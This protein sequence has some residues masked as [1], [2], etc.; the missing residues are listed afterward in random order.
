[1][2]GGKQTPRQKLIGLMYLI[3]LALM[4]LNVSVEV[5]DS[6]ALVNDG[7][8]Q[9]NRNF[10]SKV[11]QVYGDFRQQEAISKEKVQPYYGEALRIKQLADSLVNNILDGRNEMIAQINEISKEEAAD[12]N[13]LDM[14]KKDNYSFS[15]RFW[16]IDNSVDPSR[17]G[18]QGTRA[19]ALRQHI[20]HFK[21]SVISILD[22]HKLA[23]YVQLGLDVDGPFYLQ[24]K[25]AE[26]SWQQLTFDR[27]IP[28]A[29]ATNMSRLVT[30]VRNAE[31]DAINMLYGAITADDYKFD[32]IA[33]RVVP[34]SQIVLLGE[35]YEA[36][37]FVAAYDSRQRPEIT[38][39]RGS[40]SVADGGVGRLRIPATAEGAQT[41]NGVI[42]LRQ[43][44]TNTPV[45]YPYNGSFIVQRPSVTV[46]AD[47]MNVFYIGL[48]NP[49]SIS[50]PGVPNERIRPTISSGGQLT[51]RGSGRYYV[52]IQ[53][54]T[55]EARITVNADIDGTSRNMG[56]STF[57]VRTVPDPVAYIANRR[58]GRISREELAV[59]RAIIPRLENFEFDMNFEIASFVMA[60]TVAGDFR[61][62]RAESNVFTQEMLNVINTATRGQRFIFENIVT[63]PG[64]DG[65]TRNLA[66]IT[67]TIN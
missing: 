52:R 24:D 39:N 63:K 48:D 27:V 42:T 25:T 7:I 14:K 3:F 20:E 46:S 58:E 22:N 13:L 47:A 34:T 16:M 53:P 66:P 65:R 67:F 41:Y 4:A 37:V 2:A 55:T 8:E 10:E 9:T 44:G 18:G 21:A 50:V 59:A 19:Y 36:E 54:G 5:L 51:S 33:A 45:S 56:T 17:P 40:V 61:P 26:I 64:P 60:T 6:F 43:P 30:E 11:D 28:V 32:E 1:M 62:Y 35:H 57:R 38:A 29:V 12:L 15:S 49:V 23:E 31:F